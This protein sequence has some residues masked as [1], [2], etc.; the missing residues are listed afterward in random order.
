MTT[1]FPHLHQGQGYHSH[2]S[3]NIVSSILSMYWFSSVIP[4]RY[5][6][7]NSLFSTNSHL[8]CRFLQF[9]WLPA[10]VQLQ[11]AIFQEASRIVV[12]RMCWEKII[13]HFW[14]GF[15]RKDS[16]VS[17]SIDNYKNLEYVQKVL[18]KNL[19]NVEASGTV[20]G[21]MYWE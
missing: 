3:R 13:V 7:L 2:S 6:K 4:V 17:T 8:S 19:E 5:R 10:T 1:F 14:K 16:A 18:S 11:T 20:V 9:S 12:G 15:F 21:G